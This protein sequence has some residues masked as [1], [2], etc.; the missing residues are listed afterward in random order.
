VAAVDRHRALKAKKGK[1]GYGD[2]LGPDLDAGC[3]L[4][5]TGP[6]DDTYDRPDPPGLTTPLRSRSLSASIAASGTADGAEP[7]LGLTNP[8]ALPISNILP[9]PA[10]AMTTKM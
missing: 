3:D 10:S 5:S 9:V 8:M 7:G 2:Q 1:H 6:M 4:A